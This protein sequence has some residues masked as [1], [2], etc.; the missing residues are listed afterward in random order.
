[1]SEAWKRW[2]LKAAEKS[3]V[4]CIWKT[5]FFCCCFLVFEVLHLQSM[6]HTVTLDL[7]SMKR[8]SAY[9]EMTSAFWE[10]KKR[11]ILVTVKKQQQKKKN[12]EEQ[13]LE[14]SKAP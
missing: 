4:R 11:S 6:L 7:V 10:K 12:P 5:S 13:E 14:K 3:K 9:I 2:N 8:S 1:M